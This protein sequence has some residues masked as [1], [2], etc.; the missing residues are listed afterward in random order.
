MSHARSRPSRP[1]CVNDPRQ[2]TW[3]ILVDD[4]SDRALEI[5]PRAAVDPR[6][7]W[8]VADV[9][10]AS[11]PTVAAALARLADVRTGERVWDPFVGSGAELVECARRGGAVALA[12]S[13][14]SETALAAAR[15]NLDAAHVTGSLVLADARR[16]SPGAVDAIVTN[17]PLGSRVRLDAGELLVECVG[18]FARQLAP[19]GRLVWITPVPRKTEVVAKRCGLRMTRSIEI[20]LGGVHGRLERWDN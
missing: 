4:T 17:P 8:R 10:A 13:D 18:H 15:A 9:P 6:F 11:H 20:D 5:V 1:S 7:E 19:N 3:D 16:H 2:T 14:T 12:G